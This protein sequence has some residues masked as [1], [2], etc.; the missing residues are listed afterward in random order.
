MY[1]RLMSLILNNNNSDI[2]LIY[3]NYYYIKIKILIN[4]YIYN[5][6][7]LNIITLYFYLL[8]I[9]THFHNQTMLRYDILP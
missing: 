4:T 2:I 1:I 8:E 9:S 7:Y 5:H 3:T 6:D